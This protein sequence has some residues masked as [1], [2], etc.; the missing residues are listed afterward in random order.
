MSVK[1]GSLNIVVYPDPVLRRKAKPLTQITDEVR[2]VAIRMIDLMHEAEGV[3]LAAPQIGLPWRMFVSVGEQESDVERIFINPIL[4][5]ASEEVE[6]HEEGCLSLP[7]IRAD[8]LRPR[9]IT[10]SAL[11][12]DGKPFTLTS[13]DLHARIWQHEFD[14][15]EGQLI[16]DRMAPI[17]KLAHQRALKSLEESYTPPRK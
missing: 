17:D 9:T 10:V 5:D 6:P 7:N 2:D 14:H 12:L 15:L 3:G 11:D 13:S 4:S 8:V 1:V 16:I